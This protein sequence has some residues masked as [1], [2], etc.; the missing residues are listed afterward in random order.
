MNTDLLGRN[1]AEIRKMTGNLMPKPKPFPYWGNGLEHVKYNYHHLM[2]DFFFQENNLKIVGYDENTDFAIDRVRSAVEILGDGMQIGKTFWRW[3]FS[4]QKF[5]FE[6]YEELML[7][8][9]THCFRQR[10]VYWA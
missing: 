2:L 8:T 1:Y 9:D 7:E 5:I 6:L 10:Y 3:D 4:E